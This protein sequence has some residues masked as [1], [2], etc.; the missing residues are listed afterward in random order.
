MNDNDWANQLTEWDDEYATAP[1]KSEFEDVPSGLYKCIVDK[2]EPVESKAGK[3]MLKWT[4]KV[5]EGDFE[6]R[7]IWKYSMMATKQN[8]HFLKVDLIMCNLRLD[9]I[10]D[11]PY[12]LSKLLDTQL[13]VKVQKKDDFN[14]V[15]FVRNLSNQ[16]DISKDNIK[17]DVPF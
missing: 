5:T 8:I 4:L 13:E 17:D 11:L 6:G 9:K 2:V 12:N 14:N 15:Y 16:D 3:P 10:S 7:L 1:E